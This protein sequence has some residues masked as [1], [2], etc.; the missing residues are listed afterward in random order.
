TAQID[1]RI[2]RHFSVYLKGENLLGNKN[3][4]YAGIMERPLNA[5]G[6]IAINF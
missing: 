6:G 1:Y 4:R 3:W 5:G 2:N